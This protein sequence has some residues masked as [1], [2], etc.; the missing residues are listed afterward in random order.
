[1]ATS[2][3]SRLCQ[4]HPA[5][6]CRLRMQYRMAADI[7][8]ISSQ[9]VY[10]GELVCGS[11]AR[12]VQDTSMTCPGHVLRRARLRLPG[13]GQ[14]D[15]QPAAARPRPRRARSPAVPAGGRRVGR[16]SLVGG[17]GGRRRGRRVGGARARAAGGVA[18]ARHPAAAP[19]GLPRHGRHA[20]DRGASP[21][22]SRPA[23]EP[24]R[25]HRHRRRRRSASAP[26]SAAATA[27]AAAAS[28][29]PRPPPHPVSR[30]ASGGEARQRLQPARGGP[31]R[32]AA[33]PISAHL[34]SSRAI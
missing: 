27:A 19:R 16:G 5:A 28:H 34:G 13:G 7:M 2:L 11:P 22:A 6:V 26:A 9:L 33:R 15:A 3:F 23:H 1:M 21:G 25:R 17:G 14:R 30:G 4:A 18:A 20:R 29:L 10:S 12:D 24:S 31:R 8:A 32:A